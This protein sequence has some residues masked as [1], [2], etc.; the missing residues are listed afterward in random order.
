MPVIGDVHIVTTRTRRDKRT[1]EVVLR[2]TYIQYDG[3]G[4]VYHPTTT[5]RF[6]GTGYG[7]MG[8][9]LVNV[10]SGDTPP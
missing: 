3:R 9:F 6:S 4:W 8:D 2:F 5:R 7:E 1:G 10:E